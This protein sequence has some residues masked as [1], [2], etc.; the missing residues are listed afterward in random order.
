MEE[1]EIETVVAAAAAAVVVV[2][3]VVA[4]V[5]KVVAPVV[6]V[7]WLVIVFAFSLRPFVARHRRLASWSVVE[8]D[9]FESSP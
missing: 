5:G 7:L 1:I 2:V 9:R 8:S 6:V 3:V 4:V